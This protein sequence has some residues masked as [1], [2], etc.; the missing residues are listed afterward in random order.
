M[1]GLCRF[2]ILALPT[3]ELCARL[4]AG[5]SPNIGLGDSVACKVRDFP[6]I[7][8]HGGFAILAV[9]SRRDRPCGAG[10]DAMAVTSIGAVGLTSR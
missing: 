7:L 2:G 9:S 1:R 4:V 8:L 5:F 3:L 6:N 10:S